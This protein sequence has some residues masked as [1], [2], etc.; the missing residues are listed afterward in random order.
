[1]PISLEIDIADGMPPRPM[2]TLGDAV[3]QRTRV[4]QNIIARSA[5]RYE[6]LGVGTRRNR[7]DMTSVIPP[8]AE[9]SPTERM[10][11]VRRSMRVLSRHRQLLAREARM[12]SSNA[13]LARLAGI[14]MRV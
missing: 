5:A 2:L 4:I 1:M 9:A 8:V 12:M 7:T 3:P 13:R 11:S 6:A 10:Q 14:A